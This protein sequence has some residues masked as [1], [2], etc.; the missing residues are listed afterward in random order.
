MKAPE[1]AKKAGAAGDRG[2]APTQTCG[3]KAEGSAEPHRHRGG[4]RTSRGQRVP[5][6]PLGG[7][8]RGIPAEL[9]PP[10][11]TVPAA[12]RRSP[13]LEA[14][15]GSAA[16]RQSRGSRTAVRGRGSPIAAAAAGPGRTHALA[17]AAA[18][19]RRN[20]G[21]SGGRSA[22]RPLRAPPGPA[23]HCSMTSRRAGGAACARHRA[24]GA[25][26][27]ASGCGIGMGMRDRD[28]DAGPGCGRGAPAAPRLPTAG[29]QRRLRALAR[30]GRE[31]GHRG[32]C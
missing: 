7:G 24:P 16:Q 20:R 21:T 27:P 12:L 10:P 11:G 25:A 29:A 8:S 23:P 9:P 17:P 22:P 13:L 28:A 3:A 15:P 30:G 26:G 1:G 32:G 4:G 2:D 31:L 18:A 5:P 14:L 19:A 6:E